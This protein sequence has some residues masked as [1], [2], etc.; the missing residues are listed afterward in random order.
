[1]LRREAVHTNDL[2]SFLAS[3]STQE[4]AMLR[5]PPRKPGHSRPG[6]FNI[7]NAES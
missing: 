7:N 2:A 6:S 4:L 1:M 3:I 5:G